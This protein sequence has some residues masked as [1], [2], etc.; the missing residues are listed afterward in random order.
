M[1]QAATPR[2]MPDRN[3][4]FYAEL[5][6][7]LAFYTFFPIWDNS[8][9]LDGH[10]KSDALKKVLTYSKSAQAQTTAL[11]ERQKNLI[12]KT[13]IKHRLSITAK[14][15]SPFMTGTG[16]EHPLENGF[17][18]LQPYGLPYLAGSSI[19]GVL[20]N[21]ARLLQQNAFGEGTQGWT[22][23][24]IETLFGSDDEHTGNEVIDHARRG[25]LTF[26]DVIILPKEEIKG[27][28]KTRSLKID[29]LT[30]HQS[31]YLQGTAS[32]HDS[33]DPVPVPFLA[34]GVGAEFNFHIQANPA[35]LDKYSD[36]WQSLIESCFKYTFD[37][38]GFGAKT[39]VGYG[40]LKQD[41]AQAK[42]AKEERE[43]A[44]ATA[45]LEEENKGKSDNQKLIAYFKANLPP[46]TTWKG[47][48]PNTG[49][50]I[51]IKGQKYGFGELC[52]LVEKWTEKADIQDALDLF[53]DKLP[54]WLGKPIKD[55]DKWK[56]RINALKLKVS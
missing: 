55:N 6:P 49:I 20:R 7:A 54:T 39:A 47:K 38:L 30:P 46:E 28:V 41:E 42:A 16:M 8:W 13:D 50:S 51:E 40:V 2:Y 27:G 33:G 1:G 15:I 37:W 22:P 21:T 43:N 26:W 25:A 12:S 32:P 36:T 11:I 23:L 44:Q 56:K 52:T 29:I 4:A 35:L 9:R 5:S 3:D 17:A 31:H 45:K 53:N 10:Y 14:S 48:G 18:F 34:V 24:A 19:K